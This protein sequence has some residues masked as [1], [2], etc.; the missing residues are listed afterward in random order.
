MNRITDDFRRNS[1]KSPAELERE[2]DV[3]RAELEASLEEL[4]H[5]LSPT[6]IVS[7]LMTRVRR[8]GMELA[9]NLG[10][11]VK[12]NPLPALLTSV[13]IVWLMASS[14]H[15]D[16]YDRAEYGRGLRESAEDMGE[17]WRETREGVG[18]HW[19]EAREGVG[20]RWRGA[21]D[22][23]RHTRESAREGLEHAREMI[24]DSA[25][26]ARRRGRELTA[27]VR[28]GSVRARSGLE[29]L[30]HEQPLMLGVLGFA[31][32][33]IAGAAFPPTEQ[34]DEVLGPMRDRALE[35]AKST[36]AR[37]A[38]Q[39]RER[40]EELAEDAKSAMES[41]DDGQWTPQGRPPGEGEPPRPEQQ[42]HS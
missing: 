26:S 7:N 32:G 42:H 5:R 25:S 6:D 30:W 21:K 4:E 33:A 15:H 16:G 1:Q 38:R 12:E 18:E 20:E 8:D 10:H 17:H 27:S 28:R 3:T 34:E 19:R 39:L 9:E 23:A 2:I 37:Q 36:G 11:S 35:R 41:G 22:R 14:R 24:T 29:H 40:G 13:G 31:A